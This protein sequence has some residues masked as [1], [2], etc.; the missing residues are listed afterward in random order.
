MAHVFRDAVREVATANGGLAS[1]P[2]AGVRGGTTFRTFAE[3][4]IADGDTLDYV[5][6]GG[7][8]REWGVASYASGML[9]RSPAG[10][11]VSG[12]VSGTG[13]A[14]PA[15]VA[16]TIGIVLTAARAAALTVLDPKLAAIVALDGS[17]GLLAQTGAASFA[18][19]TLAGTA[20]E[21]AVANGDGAAGAPAISLPAALTLTGKNV[22]GGSF[23]AVQAWGIRSSGV[24]AFDLQ[25]LN[26]EELTA[27]R[28][29]TLKVNDAPR[30]IDLAG[31]LM[32]GGAFST[33][34][35][36]STSG[37]FAMTLTATGATNVTLPTTG[38]LLATPGG[39]NLTG[40]FTCTSVDQGIKSSG[41]FTL[42]MTAGPVQHCVNGGAFALAPPTGH[43]SLT[44]DITNNGTAGAITTSGFTKVDGD[45]FT[46]TNGHAF[47][48]YVGV[49]QAGA[50]LTVKRMT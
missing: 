5:A 33:A 30:T 11:V 39:Q 45:A 3:A 15:G 29:L 32:L 20:N 36:F 23:A 19:R 2:L 16:V 38:T 48:C 12:V 40:G 47:R 21:I 28:A 31:S 8:A 10:S 24:G 50:H 46:T 44:L 22:T 18:K 25:L 7:G 14:F 35:A 41:T 27:N 17:A 43:G 26:T 4:A 37:A 42:S 49:G 6:E 1:F 13:Y 34:A 9:T